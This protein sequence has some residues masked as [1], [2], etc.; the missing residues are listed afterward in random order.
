MQCDGSG[1]QMSECRRARGGR[2]GQVAR[3]QGHRAKHWDLSWE[4]QS[5]VP[6]SPKARGSA[7]ARPPASGDP[8][9][10][11]RAL[12]PFLCPWFAQCGYKEVFLIIYTQVLPPRLREN[13]AWMGGCRE[14]LAHHYLGAEHWVAFYQLGK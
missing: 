1:K 5:S 8:F 10:R 6:L 11:T 14:E 3:G 4:A 9:P 12:S 7:K 13:P 2:E